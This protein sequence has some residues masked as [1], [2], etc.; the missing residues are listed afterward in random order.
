MQDWRQFADLSTLFG[1]GFD[2]V[3]RGAVTGKLVVS[4]EVL[5]R[6]ELIQRLL[7]SFQ[8][9]DL[10][11]EVEEPLLPDAALTTSPAGDHVVLYSKEKLLDYR[12]ILGSTQRPLQGV[13]EDSVELSHIMLLHLLIVNPPECLGNLGCRGCSDLASLQLAE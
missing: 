3:A 12:V 8:A 4:L 5:E 7:D 9:L 10:Q 6:E 11:A 2:A 13:K 1:V